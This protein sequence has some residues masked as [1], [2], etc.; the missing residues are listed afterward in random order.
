MQAIGALL[1]PVV[2]AGLA[3]VLTRNQSRSQELVRARLEYYKLLAPDL[4]RVM[5]YITFIGGW[6]DDSPEAIIELK[7]RLDGHFYCAAPLF[8]S[9]VLEAYNELMELSFSTFGPWGKDASIKS[10]AYRRRQA[11]RGEGDNAWRSEWD[12]YFTLQDSEIIARESLMDYRKTYDKLLAAAVHDLDI[13]RA[14][15]QYTTDLVKL[16][17]H[18]PKIEDIPGK[19]S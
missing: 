19:S 6:R 12:S 4:N 13:T 1:V 5:C 2:V 14:R 15:S 11:W 7:R 17:A 3:Y 9:G 10:N 18:L 8:S 16:N